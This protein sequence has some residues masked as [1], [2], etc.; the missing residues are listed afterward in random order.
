MI[1][2]EELREGLGAHFEVLLRAVKAEAIALEPHEHVDRRHV[3]TTGEHLLRA[4]SGAKAEA[5]RRATFGDGAAVDAVQRLHRNGALLALLG[6]EDE[7][8]LLI[9]EPFD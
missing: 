8:S 1:E 6:A 2:R 3:R 4:A 5:E 7:E 9:L